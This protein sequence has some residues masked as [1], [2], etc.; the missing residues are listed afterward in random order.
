M[1]KPGSL[2]H[3]APH[4]HLRQISQPSP[5]RQE[6]RPLQSGHTAVPYQR[7]RPKDCTRLQAGAAT[8][9]D[10]VPSENFSQQSPA[11]ARLH[12]N[13]T[14][15][16]KVTDRSPGQVQRAESSPQRIHTLRMAVS[17]R[18]PAD[19]VRAEAEYVAGQRLKTTCST[20]HFLAASLVSLRYHC[21]DDSGRPACATA[22]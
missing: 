3:P 20:R 19:C 15:C 4:V 1:A 12:V 13:S 2:T 21:C 17:V 22:C 5:D 7:Y 10:E 18:F 9:G 6:Q 8:S 11:P 14:S 16:R